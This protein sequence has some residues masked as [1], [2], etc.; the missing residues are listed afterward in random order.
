M[1]FGV[2]DEMCVVTAYENEY[3]GTRTY[4]KCR[5]WDT[6]GGMKKKLFFQ[7]ETISEAS[8]YCRNP[9]NSEKPW[10]YVGDGP[11]HTFNCVLAR[12]SGRS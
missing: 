2:L 11:Y 9:D 7:G 4:P 10:C 8:N 5:R 3:R 1:H 12:C 6:M